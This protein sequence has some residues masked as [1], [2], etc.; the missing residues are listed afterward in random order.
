MPQRENKSRTEQTV[1]NVR[2][3]INSAP[4]TSLLR[5]IHQVSVS[6]STCKV[7]SRRAIVL[8]PHKRRIMN[9]YRLIITG[10]CYI[11]CGSPNTY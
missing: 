8:F 6:Y 11:A 7:I 9:Y 1:G 5:V 2:E 4:T 10:A 3:T